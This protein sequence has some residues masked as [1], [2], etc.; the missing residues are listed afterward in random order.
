M[1]EA[2]GRIALRMAG[3]SDSAIL[4]INQP[5]LPMST[6]WQMG[7]RLPKI[8]GEAGGANDH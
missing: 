3:F 2:E 4:D 8:S 7:L 1:V 5:V 6:G